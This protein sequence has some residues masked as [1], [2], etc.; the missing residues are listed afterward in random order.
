MLL[1][2]QCATGYYRSRYAGSMRSRG[3]L[4]DPTDVFNRR[5]KENSLR[6]KLEDIKKSM[7]SFVGYHLHN[8]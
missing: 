1:N 8:R 6:N 3:D 4:D 2:H 5:Q 7:E